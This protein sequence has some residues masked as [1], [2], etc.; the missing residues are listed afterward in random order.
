MNA[1][2][3]IQSRLLEFNILK[4][5]YFNN[6]TEQQKNSC[7]AEMN[8]MRAAVEEMN[9]EKVS[10]YLNNKYKAKVLY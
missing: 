1:S 7:L 10:N 3:K 8:D 6:R 9:M 4:Y 2:H 5:C